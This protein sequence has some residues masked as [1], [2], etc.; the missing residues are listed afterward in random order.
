M[1]LDTPERLKSL[2]KEHPWNGQTLRFRKLTIAKW[3]ELVKAREAMVKDEGDEG[4]GFA[5]GALSLSQQLCDESGCLVC[6]TDE[7][8]KRL[9]SE[10]SANEM[11]S[12]LTE[13]HTWSGIIAGEAKK[14]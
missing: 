14:N 1:N 8:R 10:L 2:I 9:A 4:G 7:W 3:K 11:E 13:A 5:W 6:D 12:L